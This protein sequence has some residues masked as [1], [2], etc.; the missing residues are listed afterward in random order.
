MSSDE[1]SAN[2]ILSLLGVADLFECVLG[3]EFM[4]NEVCKPERK[5]FDMVLEYL[6]IE[7]SAVCYFEDSFKNLLAG[8]ALGMQTVF[9]TSSTLK[10]EGKT[11]DDLDQFDAVVEG[12]VGESSKLKLP[13]LR[14]KPY[15]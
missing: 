1:A 5:A 8:K 11:V 2:E 6:K 4:R 10:N 12:K 15:L 13:S 9:V 3:T 7:P 14:D